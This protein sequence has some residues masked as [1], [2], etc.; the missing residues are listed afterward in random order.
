MRLEQG[1]R[2]VVVGSETTLL[3]PASPHRVGT[4]VV[5]PSVDSIQVA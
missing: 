2:Y 1:N 5:C 3:A 4:A